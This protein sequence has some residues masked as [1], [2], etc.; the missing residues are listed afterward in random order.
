M[1][2]K[3]WWLVISPCFASLPKEVLLFSTAPFLLSIEAFAA[4]V[5]TEDTELAASLSEDSLALA[6]II[7]LL[8]PVDG[9]T[10]SF[11]VGYFAITTDTGDVMVLLHS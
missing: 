1:S 11:P 4:T 2:Q 10:I 3:I 7:S 5:V 8:S 6:L 9:G